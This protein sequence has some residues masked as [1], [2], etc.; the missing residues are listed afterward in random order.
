MNWPFSNVTYLSA[1]IKLDNLSSRVKSQITA[2]Y[3]S[4]YYKIKLYLTFIV[5][6][7]MQAVKM[8]LRPINI[9]ALKKLN[10]DMA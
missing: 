10:T 1:F 4:V 7:M 5:S 9:L 6:A 8:K 3:S 2:Q